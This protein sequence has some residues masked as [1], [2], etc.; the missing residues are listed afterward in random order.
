M[1]FYRYLS[2]LYKSKP[3]LRAH[4][5][6]LWRKGSRTRPKKMG[7]V[8]IGFSEVVCRYLLRVGRERLIQ[9]HP[10]GFGLKAG[11]KLMVSRFLA[12]CLSHYTKL[13]LIKIL[14]PSQFPHIRIVHLFRFFWR[15][16]VMSK[17]SRG[18]QIY[19]APSTCRRRVREQMLEKK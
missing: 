8:P 2:P 7:P 11:L 6:K 16:H 1:L 13:P 3:G 4:P 14:G 15:D 18:C 19:A 10:T 17:L 5:D 9:G 12:W